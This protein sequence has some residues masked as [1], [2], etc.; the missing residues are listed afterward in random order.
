MA[1]IRLPDS[2]PACT[3]LSLCVQN[4]RATS[5]SLLSAPFGGKESLLASPPAGRSARNRRLTT[6]FRSLRMAARFQATVPR[7]KL[8]ACRFD[9]PLR[10]LR[11]R[12]VDYSRRPSRLATGK[13]GINAANPLP[14][15][16]STVPASPRTSRSPPG[17]RPSGSPRRPICCRKARLPNPPDCPSLP[18]GSI[19]LVHLRITVPGSLRFRR[20]A[21]PRR[22]ADSFACRQAAGQLAWLFSSFIL[23]RWNPA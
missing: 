19:L 16:D 20:P 23:R 7:S 1:T 12:S 5:G 15:S 21:V 11:T 22:F 14:D 10:L 8:P 13:V 6:T 2:P 3:A 4:R 9:A 18:A 17:L